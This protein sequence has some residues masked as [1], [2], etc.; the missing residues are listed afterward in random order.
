MIVDPDTPRETIKVMDFGLAKLITEAPARK[1]TDT[2]VD[3]AV[4]TPGYIAPEQ[5]R[6]EAMDHRGDLYSVGV[7]AYELL[8][9]RLPF[10]GATSMDVLLAHATEAPPTFREIGL[11]G[12]APESVESLVL[13]L[14]AKEPD[15][16]PQS[17]R[18]LAERLD[19]AVEQAQTRAD[20]EWM[21]PGHPRAA[22][23]PRLADRAPIYDSGT[24]ELTSA[25]T[26]DS[27]LASA[28]GL[29]ATPADL[30]AFHM[31]AWMPESIAIIKLR[32]FVHDLGG[33]VLESVPGLTR[34]RLGKGRGNPALGWLGLGR[35]TSAI[36]L[37]LHMHRLDANAQRKNKLTIQVLFRPQNLRQLSDPVWRDRC[38]TIFVEL[39]AYL[40]GG[41]S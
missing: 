4:G 7:M 11:E 9:G 22:D 36:E 1:V 23:V 32:G 26:Q 28:V 30:L 29:P 3:F 2:N 20:L 27:D 10:N 33:E 6:G 15:D 16:R 40:M 17:A 8:T 37:E 25:S 14:L 19:T 13:E 5:I 34:V 21:P 18:E 31:E 39:R 41:S 24:I 12:I 38:T 35:R